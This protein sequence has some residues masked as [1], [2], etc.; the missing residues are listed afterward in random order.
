M[1]EA[2]D[3]LLDRPI[4]PLGLAVLLGGVGDGRLVADAV[5]AEVRLEYL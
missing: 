4:S 5:L 1:Q 3:L 2:G